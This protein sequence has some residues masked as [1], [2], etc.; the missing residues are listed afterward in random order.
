MARWKTY[1]VQARPPKILLFIMYV[2]FED[3][4]TF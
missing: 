3:F 1:L 4:D 2:A